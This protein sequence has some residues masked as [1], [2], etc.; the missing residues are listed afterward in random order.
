MIS[1]PAAD[2]LV[3]AALAE[4]R[5]VDPDLEVSDFAVSPRSDGVVVVQAVLAGINI[6]HM[7]DPLDALTK[8]DGSLKRALISSGLYEEFD[9]ARRCLR[10]VPAG[11]T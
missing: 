1:A 10:V 7:T 8:L 11:L 3:A 5:Q 4:L 9:V 6:R 2:A